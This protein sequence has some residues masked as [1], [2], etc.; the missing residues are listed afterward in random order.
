MPQNNIQN[1]IGYYYGPH[2][3]TPQ[4]SQQKVRTASGTG[5]ADVG[6]GLGSRLQPLEKLGLQKTRFPE[7][8][9]DH[10]AW[11]TSEPLRKVKL[12]ASLLKFI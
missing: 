8:V 7:L 3:I 9:R 6:L 1:N 4:A 5:F 11:L 12:L 10:Q 2:I